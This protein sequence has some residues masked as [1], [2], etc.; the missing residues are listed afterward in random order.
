[1]PGARPRTGESP[2]RS[3]AELSDDELLLAPRRGSIFLT[4]TAVQEDGTETSA[5]E[6][7]TEDE[8]EASAQENETED[9]TEASAQ[10]DD[11]EASTQEDESESS[12]EEVEELLRPVRLPTP[13]LYATDSDEDV[14]YT[15]PRPAATFFQGDRL[16]LLQDYLPT[17]TELRA[18]HS[19]RYSSHDIYEVYRERWPED[20]H[21]VREYAPDRLPSARPARGFWEYSRTLVRVSPSFVT[22]SMPTLTAHTFS[23]SR[24]GLSATFAPTLLTLNKYFGISHSQTALSV[25][26]SSPF[27]RAAL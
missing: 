14:I 5:Q 13:S 16:T 3:D 8:T 15:N 12:G 10:E 11:T 26:L 20:M 24:P 1:M 2:A 9:E 23:V 25:P 6:D 7:E 4:A 17:Y 19:I 22:V 21:R 27:V 18:T